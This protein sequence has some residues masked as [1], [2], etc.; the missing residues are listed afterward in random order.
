MLSRRPCLFLQVQRTYQ[1]VLIGVPK[2]VEGTV[3]TNIVRDQRDRQRMAV[4]GFFSNRSALLLVSGI[5]RA[6]FDFAGC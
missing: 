4:T 3:E 2:N 5:L 1:S 6:A